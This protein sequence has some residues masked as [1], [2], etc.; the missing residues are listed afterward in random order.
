MFQKFFKFNL[1][2]NN[3]TKCRSF[4][5]MANTNKNNKLFC[6]P[7]I[8]IYDVYKYCLYENFLSVMKNSQLFFA[9]LT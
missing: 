9:Y 6:F 8:Y 4:E 1:K 7:Y 5:I 2:S 3:Y